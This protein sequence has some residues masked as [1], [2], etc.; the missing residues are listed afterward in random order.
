MWSRAEFSWSAWEFNFTWVVVPGYH[1]RHRPLQQCL[2][3]L[4]RKNLA[5]YPQPG[6]LLLHTHRDLDHQWDT[7]FMDSGWPVYP[8]WVRRHHDHQGVLL[9]RRVIPV[10]KRISCSSRIKTKFYEVKEDNNNCKQIMKR[11]ANQ[12]ASRCWIYWA[13]APHWTPHEVKLQCARKEPLI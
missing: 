7:G 10:E 3:D 12:L 8:D 11:H 13:Y 2:I 9:P 5:G 1:G 6:L 4:P